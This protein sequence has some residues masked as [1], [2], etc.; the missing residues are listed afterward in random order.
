MTVV[1][2]S[3]GVRPTANA[4]IASSL[5]AAGIR[6][7]RT[8]IGTP[9]SAGQ[10]GEL[11]GDLLDGAQRGARRFGVEEAARASPSGRA[12]AVVREQ[13][14]VVVATVGV[15]AD[16][17]AHHVRPAPGVDLLAHAGPRSGPSRPR[18]RPGRRA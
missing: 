1:E 14:G 18:C 2:T 15:G 8:P 9:A 4:A 5:A 16:P 12:V 10:R 13:V 11:G 6:P 3:T 17:R 7:C